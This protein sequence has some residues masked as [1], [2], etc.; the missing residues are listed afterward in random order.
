MPNTLVQLEDAFRSAIRRAFDRHA[1]PLITPSQNPRFGDYQSNAAMGLAKVLPDK[2]NSR[3]VAEQIVR[4]LDLGELSSDVAIAGPGFINVRLSPKWV[5]SQLHK[6]ATDERLGV[7]VSDN[8]QTVVIDYSSPNI[9]K[10]LHVGHLR[11]SIIGDALVRVLEFEGHKVIRQNHVGDW[12]TQFGKIILAIWHLFMA[13][14]RGEPDYPERMGQ[15]LA[16]A[17]D[18]ASARAKL[19]DE[20]FRR[21]QEDLNSDMEGLEFGKFLDSYQPS[22][23]QLLPA[24]QF[25]S[26]VEAAPESASKELRDRRG[27]TRLNAV[28]RT[29]ASDLQQ[30]DQANPLN[31]QERNAW[32]KVKEV[33]LAQ[34]QRV[35]DQL[36]L[37]LTIADEYGES[38]YDPALPEVVCALRKAGVAVE[39]EGAVVVF[40]DGPDKPPFIIEKSGGGGYLYGTTDLAAVR[41]R[42][43]ELHADR[44][45]YVVGAPQSKHLS[46]LF[47][48][49]K[50]AGWTGNAV[51]EHVSFGSVLGED[52]K[53][54]KT[55]SG[56]NVKLADLL[57][58]AEERALKVVEQKNPDLDPAQQKQIARAV[59]IGAVKYADLSKDRIGDYL[60][61]FDQMLAMEGNTAPYL[62]YAFARVRSIFRK[63]GVQGSDFRVQ[64]LNSEFELA[65][66]KHILRLQEV[67]DVVARDLKPHYLCSYLFE[68]ATR[69]SAFFENCPVLKSEGVTRES[70][71]ALCDLTARTLKVGLS[72][73]GIETIE[74]M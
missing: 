62:Q 17:K 49:A 22:L 60:F 30:G 6:L 1:D 64:E 50:K 56:E 53:M 48:V 26:A 42:V 15:R 28:S 37:K 32:R 70:R 73:L 10:E 33:T 52:G 63:G 72:L 16:S 35:Y 20:V 5:V 34:C 25:V 4:A 68:L 44:I 24:Y 51:L 29:V 58:E 13:Q 7:A 18:D 8:P 47:A 9:A 19:I 74:Q 31:A 54:L 3:Q 61:S 57:N 12:G 14:K 36:G 71:L 40:I 23:P 67:L 2:A 43:N 11:S 69:F 39:S 38:K 45:I 65:L 41:Y 55:R 27:I 46:Q 59:G 21:H 66:A